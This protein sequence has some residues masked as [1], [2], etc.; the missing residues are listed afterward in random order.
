MATNFIDALLRPRQASVPELVEVLRDI[1]RGKTTNPEPPPALPAHPDGSE[2][3]LPSLVP[4]LILD[5]VAR[6]IEDLA[7]LLTPVSDPTTGSGDRAARRYS[8]LRDRFDRLE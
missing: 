7:R 3:Q 6:G 8:A 2:P 5:S 1:H 4:R